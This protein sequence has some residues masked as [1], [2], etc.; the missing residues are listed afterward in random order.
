MSNEQ[1]PAR[2]LRHGDRPTEPLSFDDAPAAPALQVID[3]P[4]VEELTP[5]QID[6][7]WHAMP[8]GADGW[9]KQ[10][11]YQQFAI[12]IQQRVL[13]RASAFMFGTAR[14]TDDELWDAT[15]RDRDQY[16]EWA[17]KLAEAISKHFDAYIGEHSNTNCPWAEALEAIEAA[18]IARQ[19]QPTDRD[20]VLEEA[21]ECLDLMSDSS[22]D[23]AAY[24]KREQNTYELEREH[25]IAA[26]AAAIRALKS[27]STTEGAPDA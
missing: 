3:A 19:A 2:R 21:A 12:A 11:G 18:P 9:L 10:F 5:E 25:A 27:G 14:P 20:A 26:C 22:G 4:R 6:Q 1:H 23:A 16:H 15:L 17:D 13:A 8:G 7:V 24:D